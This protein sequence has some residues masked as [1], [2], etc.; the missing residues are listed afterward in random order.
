MSAWGWNP[1]S[2]AAA[3]TVVAAVSL[4]VAIIGGARANRH[5]RKDRALQAFVSLSADIRDR[6]EGGWGKLLREDLPA[7]SEEEKRSPEVVVELEAML[8][9]L[10]WMGLVVKKELFDKDLL[11]DTLTPVIKD[12]LRASAVR[13]QADIENPDKGKKWWGNVIHLAELPEISFDI[14][15]AAREQ[16]EKTAAPPVHD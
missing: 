14:A 15:E 6:W 16:R 11:L 8:N 13:L 4:I 9:W 3:G 12:I 7:M 1:E 2:V 5:N 10:E